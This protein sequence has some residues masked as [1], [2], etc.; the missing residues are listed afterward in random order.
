MAHKGDKATQKEGGGRLISMP[1]T[2]KAAGTGHA[3]CPGDP[4]EKA[5]GCGLLPTLMG[6][7]SKE[8]ALELSEKAGI[9]EGKM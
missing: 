5:P 6:L 7:E 8:E 2:Q 9:K 4:K 3:A 1:A